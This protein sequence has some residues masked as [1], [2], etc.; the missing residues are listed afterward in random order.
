MR[1][2]LAVQWLRL[3]ASTA[4]GRGSVPDGGTKIPHAMWCGTPT[5]KYH[6]MKSTLYFCFVLN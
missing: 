6:N 2:S 4:G 3:R 1:T 5:K